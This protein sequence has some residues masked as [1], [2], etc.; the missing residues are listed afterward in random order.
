[1][2][3]HDYEFKKSPK[4]SKHLCLK[5]IDTGS[6]YVKKGQVNAFHGTIHI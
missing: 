5:I 1:M 2:L 4:D 3:C 6:E